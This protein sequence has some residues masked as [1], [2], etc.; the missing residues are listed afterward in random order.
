MK[1]RKL[2]A[3]LLGMLAAIAMPPFYLFPLLAVAYSGLF[4]LLTSCTRARQAFFESW[5]FGLGFFVTGLYWICLSL[6]VDLSRFGWLIPFALF[7]LNGLIALFPALA[8]WVFYKASPPPQ[9]GEGNGAYARKSVSAVG[10][11]RFPPK[12][13][14]KRG[15]L[16]LFP[17]VFFASEYARG[18]MFTGF[19]WNLSG[20]TWA[21]SAYTLQLTN[22]IGIYG[23]TLLTLCAAILPAAY[24][25][26]YKKIA[27]GGMLVF[28]LLMSVSAIR[29]VN[30]PPT[31]Y[32]EG[33]KLRLV[34]PNIPQSQK[35]D[36]EKAASNL[37]T[38][39][40]M[41]VSHSATHIIWPEA[42]IPFLLG[43]DPELG[44]ILADTLAENQW[45]LAGTLRVQEGKVF[46][47]LVAINSNGTQA[48]Y[49][50]HHL[51][52]FGEYVPLRGIFPIEKITPGVGDLSAGGDLKTIVL[53]GTPPFS[54]LICY[55]AIFPGKVTDGKAEWLLA[56]TNDAWFGRSTGP[57]Q[58]FAMARV[59]A[60]EEGLPLVRV[61]NTGISGVVDS[62]GR[63]IATIPLGTQD[64]LEIGL[65]K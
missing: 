10:G 39:I 4:F 5:F 40:Q 47:S 51:V 48:S 35:W 55:E 28:V 11:G 60:V 36:P 34:Q 64:V 43:V 46:N 2:K 53:P 31:E 20:Y 29:L 42:A 32:V 63:I 1:N 15:E 23:L 30:A 24:V 61:A 17:L 62:Y 56:V 8:G 65:P 16:I 52:P 18:H 50:K 27:L 25:R 21:F 9:A 6:T 49:D 38:L 57:Y 33:I 13:P 41:S 37:R 3:Y 26:G 59:R 45:L 22:F 7:G 58:H 14:R 12:S 44:S 19:P 54:P